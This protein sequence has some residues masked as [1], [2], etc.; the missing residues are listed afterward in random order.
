VSVS[1]VK[2]IKI[3]EITTGMKVEVNH[4]LFVPDKTIDIWK[5]L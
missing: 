4:Q 2:V 1:G 3:D 5:Y